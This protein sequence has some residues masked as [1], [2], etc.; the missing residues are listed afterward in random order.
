MMGRLRRVRSAMPEVGKKR[1]RSQTR[2]QAELSRALLLPGPDCYGTR[3]RMNP[4]AEEMRNHL[5]RA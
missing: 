5:P 1:T 4:P 2:R 3:Q